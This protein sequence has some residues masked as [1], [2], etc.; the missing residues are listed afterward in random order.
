MG[1]SPNPLYLSTGQALLLSG[2]IGE[3]LNETL[4]PCALVSIDH[5]PINVHQ[6]TLKAIILGI[7]PS[8][9]DISDALLLQPRDSVPFLD[10]LSLFLPGDLTV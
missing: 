8:Q 4:R 5:K 6:P 1:A 2:K 9:R 10:L 3:A 7:F